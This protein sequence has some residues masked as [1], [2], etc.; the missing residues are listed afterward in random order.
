MTTTYEW[1][2]NQGMPGV[3]VR[4]DEDGM[5]EWNALSLF[6]DI[7]LAVNPRR[8]KRGR[9]LTETFNEFSAQWKFVRA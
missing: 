3:Y 8:A 9:H 7:I 4:Y 2:E 1:P 6:G 5:E